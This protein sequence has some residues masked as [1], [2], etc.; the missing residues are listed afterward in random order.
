MKGRIHVAF[1]DRAYKSKSVSIYTPIY[2]LHGLYIYY[3][4]IYIGLIY[5]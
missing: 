2:V 3:I 5:R 1:I 4:Y